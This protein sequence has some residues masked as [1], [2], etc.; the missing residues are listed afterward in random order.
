MNHHHHDHDANHS[1]DHEHSHEHSHHHDHGNDH[2]PHHKHTHDHPH[3]HTTQ[4]ELSFEEKLSTLFRHWIDHNDSHKDNYAAWAKKAKAEKLT[5]TATLLLE[6]EKQS[7]V[8]TKTLEKAL[9][10]LTSS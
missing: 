2:G 3:T 1:H 6:A 4:M 9:N 5:Q 10:T 8:I 7:E